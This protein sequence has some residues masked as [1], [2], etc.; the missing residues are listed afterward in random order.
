MWVLEGRVKMSVLMGE[1]GVSSRKTMLW[2][3]H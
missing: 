1:G 3:F 2:D